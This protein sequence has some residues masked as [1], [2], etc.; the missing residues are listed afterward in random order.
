MINLNETNYPFYS[1]IPSR[2]CAS[3]FA[4]L[5]YTSLIIWFIQSLYVKCRP[6][7][8]AIFIFLSHLTTFIELVLRGT[9]YINILNTKTFYRICAP[10][11]SIPPRF[12][13]L[14][15]YHCLVE[16]RGKNPRRI[17]DRII[18]ITV[19]IGALIGDILLSIGN[20]LS[21]SSNHRYLS[22]R[23][24]QG[25][26]GF[27]LGLSILFYIVW[28]LSVSHTRRLYIVPLLGVS[29]TCVLIEAIYIQTISFPSLFF[30]LNQNE[31]WFYGGHLI[32]IVIALITW[33]IFH[34]RRVLPPP[35][36]DVPH[37]ETGKE[38]LPPPT[39]I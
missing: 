3:I 34:P 14:A 5:L 28:Y 9:V 24:R 27:I 8:L 19:P 22:F 39:T 29:S 35:E 18:D 7:L 26:A 17:L 25:S 30:L 38:L 13:L 32:P 33:S 21:F 11:L 10:M 20:E 1:Y 12:L 23:F 16:L 36:R 37:D 6:P 2:F 4:I 31:Y 15:N